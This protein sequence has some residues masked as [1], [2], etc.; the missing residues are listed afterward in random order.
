MRFINPFV[1]VIVLSVLFLAV[2]TPSWADK[3]PVRGGSTYGDNTGFT[4]CSDNIIND[5]LS[6]C[7]GFIPGTFTIGGNTYTGALF[8]FIEPGGLVSGTLDVIQLAG[9]TSLALTLL[10][11]SA[12]TGVFMCGSFSNNDTVVR[13]ST[14]GDP[15]MTGLP[16]TAGSSGSSIGDP[17]AVSQDVNGVVGA[18]SASGVTFTNNN[19]TAI[20]VFTQDG[21]IQGAT[22]TPA[23]A[24]APEPG[25]LVLVGVGLLALGRK[26]RRAG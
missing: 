10:D 18:F 1:K 12:P 9:T 6:N 11:P 25:S 13:D 23:T 3:L 20:A 19:S 4:A 26:F 5:P 21:N 8:V 14:P 17:Y 24:A 7:E 16:C 15:P 22:F 2:V